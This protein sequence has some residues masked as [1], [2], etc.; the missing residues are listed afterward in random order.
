M[1]V[2]SET[3]ARIPDLITRLSDG[4][5][6]SKF[7]PCIA[8]V[9]ISTTEQ[10][11]LFIDITITSK[12]LPDLTDFQFHSFNI[13]SVSVSFQSKWIYVFGTKAGNIHVVNLESF[14]CLAIPSSGKT[15]L[16]GI[17]KIMYYVFLA[18][19]SSS[20]VIYIKPS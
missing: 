6:I 2:G 4:K 20:G 17:I 9:E 18:L 13:S 1:R 3:Q 5:K 15:L 8:I 7:S 19:M 14:N 11:V 16:K 12:I 10:S